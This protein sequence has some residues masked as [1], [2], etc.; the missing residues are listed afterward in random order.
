MTFSE[1]SK[2]MDLKGKAIIRARPHVN[3]N[4]KWKHE[5][6]KLF[7]HFSGVTGF[8]LVLHFPWVYLIH[9]S[10]N[11]FPLRFFSLITSHAQWLVFATAVLTLPYPSFF[12]SLT[13]TYTFHCNCIIA[14]N[15]LDRDL[16]EPAL[17]DKQGYI[18]H[19]LPVTL[20]PLGLIKAKFLSGPIV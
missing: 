15:F 18:N 1:Y 19:E 8:L 14:S 11:C 4:Y 6:L 7:S 12:F 17:C 3:R 13:Q 16:T 20:C 9:L 2:F 5:G 10:L